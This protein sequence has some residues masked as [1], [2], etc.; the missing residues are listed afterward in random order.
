MNVSD[1]RD[2]QRIRTNSPAQGGRLSN[3][4]VARADGGSN[5]GV[6]T[7]MTRAERF[8]DEK[9]RIIESCFAK[10]DEK[11]SV[12]ESYITHIRITEDGAHP[13]SP[14]PPDSPVEGKKFRVIIVS[15]RSSG[16][17]RMH[18]ARENANG[19][20]SIGKT[21]VLDDLSVIQSFGG[22][23]ASNREE[24]VLNQRA[25]KAGFV[26]TIQKPY[27]W[28]A[29]TAKEKEFFIGSLVKIYRK[30]TGGK[31]PELLG[32]DPREKES[33]V[34][35]LNQQAREAANSQEAPPPLAKGPTLPRSPAQQAGPPTSGPPLQQRGPPALPSSLQARTSPAPAP[36]I[37]QRAPLAP[38]PSAQSRVVPAP[39]LPAH[40][41]KRSPAQAPSQSR[42]PSASVPDSQR[43]GS[44]APASPLMS[45]SSPA[46]ALPSHSET[47]FSYESAAVAPLRKRSQTRDKKPNGSQEQLP[48]PRDPAPRPRTPE[49]RSV[50]PRRNGTTPP[51]ASPQTS[52]VPSPGPP[53]P[54]EPAA[55][56]REEIHR[57]GLGPMIKK[58]SNRDVATAFRKAATAYN[59][60][61][62]RTGGAG[63]RLLEKDEPASDGPDGITGVVPAPSLVSR[64]SEDSRRGP[65]VEQ[66]PPEKPS[67]LGESVS[68]ESSLHVPEVTVTNPSPLPAPST[69]RDSS[70]E[71]PRSKSPKSK[72]LKRQKRR[73][74]QTAR[75]V[76]A[77]DIDPRLVEGR[78]AEFE[79]ILDEFGWG[80]ELGRDKK[81]DTLKAEVRRELGRVEAGSW[82]G[83]LEQKDERVDAVEKMLD[84]TIAEC[85]ELDGL[86]TLYGVELSTLNDDIAYIEAQ[87]QGLQVQ[88][89]NQKLLHAELQNLL[90]T[91]SI[92]S[93]Q[94][95]SLREASLETP[96]GLEEV[97][98]SLA[99]LF[100]A[101]VTID[102]SIQQSSNIPGPRL[103]EDGSQI[104]AFGTSGNNE[105]GSMRALKEK[106]EVYR[107]E[108]LMF[109]QR[110][111]QFMNI[112][113][114]AAVMDTAKSLEQDREGHNAKRTGKTKLDPRIHDT[115]R[116]ELWRFTPIMFFSRELDT[117]E[118]SEMMKLYE[119]PMKLL[120]QEEFRDNVIA[121]KRLCRKPT[122]EEQDL[123]FTAQERDNEGIASTA[124]RKL[125]V[126][127]SQTLARTLRSEKG[128]SSNS[129]R[130]SSDKS[131]DGK[132]HPFEV[133]MGAL[134]ELTP[135]MFTEQNF[136]V[137]FFH[138]STLHQLDF[139]D[140]VNT[141]PPE[142][143]KGT[144]LNRRIATDPDR[145]MAKRV[146]DI[147]EQIYTFWPGDLQ[148]MVEWAIKADP[149]Q[150][151]GVLLSLERNISDL[152]DTNQE[153]LVKTYQKVHV[154]LKSLFSRFLDEQIRAIEDTKVK[155]KK[156]KG[157]IAFMKTFPHFSN[158]VENM[159]PDVQLE[160][161]L[162]VR[163]MV[164]DAYVR[165][166]KAMFES[167][168]AIAK[169][170]PAVMTGGQG[171]HGQGISNDP[172]DKEALN[173]HILL[174]ENMNHY[175]E[176]VD[177]RDNL[178]LEEWRENAAA[179]MAEHL[180]LY[181]SAVIRRPLG[182]ILD[183]LESTESLIST[184]PNP[185]D[186][187]TRSSHSRSVIKKLLSANDTRELR[188]G[189]DTL[190]K[191]VE[192]HLGDADDPG[193]S[194]SLVAKVMRECAGR[195]EEIGRR[196]STVLEKVYA[197]EGGAVEW[198][199]R[200]EEVVG[201][202]LR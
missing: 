80:G 194:R 98:L 133:V 6:G 63:D 45:R 74:Q 148:N 191:R 151:I 201:T 116:K 55:E 118:W 184:T 142:A 102:P 164:N 169:E 39:G 38:E 49:N 12:A 185:A 168:Q 146:M 107:N 27:Y 51:K 125:T 53:T 163:Q 7:N 123:L 138:V 94:L 106:K 85:E 43:N 127:R 159:L 124:A 54:P 42:S 202:L 86:L 176:E 25:G 57:P 20:F 46:P 195:Y 2:R 101:M 155:I 188:R 73:S 22:V 113:F 65:A 15:V 115:A 4:G 183:F 117:M 31:A 171:M 170:S 9:R 175:L 26:V 64:F 28:Q 88:T 16:R 19:S 78:S 33:L 37:Q 128:D 62:P 34:G 83:H 111:R 172:E 10:K 93:K 187:A 96:G 180:G 68:A 192:K 141:V 145:N 179:E 150:G 197:G 112:K 79:S 178:V 95:K 147:M 13:S 110:L 58:K 32:F 129:N 21:W 167:L 135:I 139:P 174:I 90:Q 134:G 199:W 47:E 149:L 186:I 165:I 71:K 173:Y 160:E 166:N 30:Y 99:M 36:S 109:L 87:S 140:Y 50:S 122:G 132:I 137:D 196:V 120:Y 144:N 126:K 91:I 69:P 35:S 152:E 59:A 104:M 75:Y 130:H 100:K 72:E 136:I 44:P 156:R 17:V 52:R 11:G 103:S 198:E 181:L 162:D 70:P 89:A 92:S 97:E 200:P 23:P 119:K 29:G 84:R 3:D 61:K 60:F 190:R 14:P 77:L 154:R 193:L 56:S 182:K 143:R 105:L 131:R 114:Q 8:E 24:E 67:L 40:P 121:W 18:K 81:L 5:A 82:L 41:R 76:S 1:V 108:S 161:D 158:S 48:L 177:S 157:V 153:F 189:A 66:V